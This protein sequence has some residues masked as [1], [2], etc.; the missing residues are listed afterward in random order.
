MPATNRQITLQREARAWAL[1]QKG[2]TEPQI[3]AELGVS[4]PAVSLMLS[5]VENKLAARFADIALRVKLDQHHRL[6]FIISE[7][8]AAWEKSKSPKTTSRIKDLATPQQLQANQQGTLLERE[9]EMISRDPN[10]QFLSIA[11]EAMEAQRRLWETSQVSPMEGGGEAGGAPMVPPIRRV[12]INIPGSVLP[13][14][15]FKDTDDS[16]SAPAD[17]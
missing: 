12:N 10:G 17:L 15:G 8:L 11:L 13:D 6:D 16:S 3:A 5:R 9:T 14:A 2:W 1:R 4:Q 7:A